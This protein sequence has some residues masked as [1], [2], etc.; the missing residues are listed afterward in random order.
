LI[1]KQG[2]DLESVQ[3]RK[4]NVLQNLVAL[5]TFAWALLATHQQDG[6]LLS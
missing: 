6:K 5:S 3:A 4:L 1:C 2:F